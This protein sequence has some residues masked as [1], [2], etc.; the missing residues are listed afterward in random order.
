MTADALFDLDGPTPEPLDD[1]SPDARRRARQYN[2]LLSGSH[3]L[4]LATGHHI[5]LHAEAAPADD[6]DAPGRRC[7]TCTWRKQTGHHSRSYPKCGIDHRRLT[8]GA[9]TDVAAWWPGCTDHEP[10]SA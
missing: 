9:G 5:S 1:L 4:S 8:H 3:P 6:R 10:V 2:A 7:G